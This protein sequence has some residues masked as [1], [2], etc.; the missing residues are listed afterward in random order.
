[1]LPSDPGGRGPAPHRPER[2]TKRLRW[3]FGALPNVPFFLGIL[4][5]FLGCAAAGRI[6]SQRPMFENFV[7]GSRFGQPEFRPVFEWISRGADDAFWECLAI[8]EDSG[9]SHVLI[10]P[11]V[12]GVDPELVRLCATYETAHV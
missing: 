10:V 3:A 5:G 4:I 12:Q 11:N 8:F 2:V 6:V 1:M 7:D 9:F